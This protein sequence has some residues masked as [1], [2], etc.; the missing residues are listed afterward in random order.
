[1]TDDKI[2]PSPKNYFIPEIISLFDILKYLWKLK[3]VLL[4]FLLLSLIYSSYKIRNAVF[5]YEVKLSIVPLEDEKINFS[6]IQGLNEILGI[7]S[8]S[9]EPSLKLYKSL[10]R[11]EYIAEIISKDLKFIKT[12]AGPS[13][14]MEKNTIT[15]NEINE[16]N[17]I[18]VIKKIMGIPIFKSRKTN[19][20]F[21]FGFLSKLNFRNL[22]SGMTELFIAT[23]RPKVGQELLQRAHDATEEFLKKRNTNKT[24]KNIEFINSKL[25]KPIKSN[26]KSALIKMLVEQNQSLM[27]ASSDIPFVAE[28]F[29]SPIVSEFPV[30]PNAKIIIAFNAIISI[31]LFLIFSLLLFIFKNNKS[32]S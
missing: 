30:S 4:F 20:K 12:L 9:R 15:Q 10:I 27:I 8:S 7:Q 31:I 16:F 3:Y 1:M 2:Q 11:S 29:S 13:W 6:S 22:D 23:E 14:D 28:T 26:S 25:S 21:V 5:E 18:N 32:P 24:L 19:S 17:V